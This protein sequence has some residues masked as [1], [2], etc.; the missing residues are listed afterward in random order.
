MCCVIDGCYFWLG[1]RVL[2]FLLSVVSFAAERSY[3]GAS[4]VKLVKWE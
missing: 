2:F 3:R 4:A 1:M